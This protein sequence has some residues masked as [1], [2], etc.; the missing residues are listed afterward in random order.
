MCLTFRMIQAASEINEGCVRT[1]Q[2]NYVI[3]IF[4]PDNLADVQ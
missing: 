1:S 3:L 4:A 2:K